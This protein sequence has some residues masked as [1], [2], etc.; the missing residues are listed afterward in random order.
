MLDVGGGLGVDY[1]GSQSDTQS[2]MNY[3]LQ[4]YAN[5]VVT[6]V[7]RVCNDT[8]VEPPELLSESGRAVA[9][10]HS[11]LVVETLGVTHQGRDTNKPWVGDGPRVIEDGPPE[12]YEP[13]VAELWRTFAAITPHNALQ[14]YHD[15][16]DSM[17]AAMSSFAGGYLP[18]EQ[19]VAAENLYFALCHRVWTLTKTMAAVPP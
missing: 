7:Q 13:S 19:R 5:D 14:S 10:H 4:E 6:L 18:L 9:A 1:D 17:D 8:S 12:D 15:A 11:V 2:S 16:Q 3:T